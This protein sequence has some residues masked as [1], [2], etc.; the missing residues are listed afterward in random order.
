VRRRVTVLG[1]AD[2]H[3]AELREHY[4]RGEERDRLDRSRTVAPLR[5]ADDAIVIDSTALDPQAVVDRMLEV[6]ESAP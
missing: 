5:A 2:G 6:I 4:A 1:M 3:E